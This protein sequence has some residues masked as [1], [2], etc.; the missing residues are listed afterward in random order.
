MILAD[1]TIWVDHLR[2]PDPTLARLAAG[3]ELVMHPFVIGELALG[4]IAKR[5]LRL[6]EWADLPVAK[7]LRHDDILAFVETN[8]LYSRGIGY[9]DVNLLASAATSDGVLLWTRDGSLRDLAAEFG[10]LAKLD[11]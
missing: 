9:T 2:S 11:H 5:A 4:S 6:K 1:T 3:A 8:R 7:V 10:V